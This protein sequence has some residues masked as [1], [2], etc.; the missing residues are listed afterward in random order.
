LV[1]PSDPSP[2]WEVAIQIPQLELFLKSLLEKKN[3]SRIRKKTF[4]LQFCMGTPESNEFAGL[5]QNPKKIIGTPNLS[6]KTKNFKK[7]LWF[8]SLKVERGQKYARTESAGPT[9]NP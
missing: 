4:Y 1:I 5:I 9:Q 3:V 6:T 8:R 7:K 2:N